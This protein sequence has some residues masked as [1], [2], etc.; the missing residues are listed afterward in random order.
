MACGLAAVASVF[1]EHRALG[2]AS[3]SGCGCGLRSCSSA[4]AAQGSVMVTLRFSCSLACGMWDLLGSAV[5]PMSPALAGFFIFESTGKPPNT[6]E[7][8]K[9]VDTFHRAL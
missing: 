2:Q 7:G 5:E 9:L 1:A 4:A 3:F 6:L 8:S